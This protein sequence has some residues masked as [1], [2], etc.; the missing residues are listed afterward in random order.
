MGCGFSE[1][2]IDGKNMTEEE[3]YKKGINK[4]KTHV[5]FM[6]GTSDL[7]IE[8]ITTKGEKILIF[9]DGD[10]YFPSK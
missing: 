9:K 7:M 8:A 1:A 5:D 3:R 4:S 2:I 10:F 6:I